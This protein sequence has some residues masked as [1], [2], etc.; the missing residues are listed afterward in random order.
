MKVGKAKP[1]V[2]EPFHS[3]SWNEVVNRLVETYLSHSSPL[4]PV[5][6]REDM[7]KAEQHIIHA[8]AAV[9]ATRR[10]CPKEIYDW[11][12]FILKQEMLN[13]YV[14]S[15]PSRQNVQTFLVT[16]AWSTSLRLK[17]GQQP[18]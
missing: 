10:N 18:L 11:L 15:D 4:L 8:V 13:L 1:F 14:I 17:V 9:A 6:V 16:S 5:F 2:T 12:K 7:D 3:P